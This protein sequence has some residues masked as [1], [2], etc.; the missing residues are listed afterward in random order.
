VTL[1]IKDCRAGWYAASRRRK[2]DR[3]EQPPEWP[4]QVKPSRAD[5]G[6]GGDE[7][8]PGTCAH[9]SP[10]GR[11]RDSST[12][13]MS[14]GA[15]CAAGQVPPDAHRE[16]QESLRISCTARPARETSAADMQAAFD[17]Q[18]KSATTLHACTRRSIRCERC[19]ASRGREA[20]SRRELAGHQDDRQIRR[21]MAPIEAA[22][23]GEALG[24]G[25][26]RYPV[27]LE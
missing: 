24:R 9:E 16:R 13:A 15:D 20:E 14:R 17:L 23:S 12:P 1:D 21:D 5:S 11:R 2:E 26:L 25:T 22:Y 4:D 8:L 10:V 3:L 6:G 18:M 27:M 19:A 7:S